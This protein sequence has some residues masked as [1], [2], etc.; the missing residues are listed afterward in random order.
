[1][2]DF[3]LHQFGNLRRRWLYGLMAG[4]MA[5]GLIV[6]SPSPSHS[7]TVPRWLE[8]LI[9]GAQIVQISN[10]SERQ[11]LELGRQ[12]NQQLLTQQFRLYR[13]STVSEYVN[14]VGQG[15]V[16]HSDRP[17]IPYTFQVVES[18]QINAFATMGGYVYVTT[19]LLQAMD[20]EAELAGVLG[21]EIGHIASRHSVEQLR[22]RAIAAGAA[23]AAGLDRNTAVA[24]GVELAIN[25]PN[26][27]RDEY[28]ADERGLNNMIR[29]G[30]AP[31]GLV[32]FM[33]KLQ[34]RGG[35]VP[36]FLSTHPNS[37]ERAARLRQ[38][39]D[40][41]ALTQGKGLDTADY[42]NQI[43]PLVR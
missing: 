5:T 43:R 37:G 25:R 11:E 30:Y 29:A 23:R 39:V 22:D 15:L 16:P 28:E 14:R 2:I 41:A 6:L 26:S 38:M 17:Q 27:R 18:N 32:S 3:L 24:L 12:I 13:N 20:N 36:T 35:S 31:I 9:R 1:M 40:E 33:E 34:Q 10:M 8:L 19:A 42:R 21:H 7:Q 4:V